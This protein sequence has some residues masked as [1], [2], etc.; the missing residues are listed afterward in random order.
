MR[1]I[2]ALLIFII[3]F[4]PFE[5][6]SQS[7]SKSVS[8]LLWQL[9]YG[10][11]TSYAFGSIHLAQQQ[12]YP[13]PK[14]VMTGFNQSDAL[15][16]EV[17]L[18][19]VT[20]QHMQALIAKYGIDSKRP[21]ASYLSKKTLKRYKDFCQNKHLPCEQFQALKPWLVSVTITA[22]L[23]AQAGFEPQYGIDKYFIAQSA[24]QKPVLP[25]ETAEQQLGLFGGLSDEVQLEM[26]KQTLSDDATEFKALIDA[27]HVGDEKALLNLFNKA[28]GTAIE[29]LFFE[30]LLYRRNVAM[31]AKLE[32]L[33]KS[34]QRLFVVIGTAHLIG[35]DNVLALL[36]A[37]GVKVTPWQ[38]KSAR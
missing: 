9:E 5:S 16:V 34:G 31:S 23:S 28:K 6:L 36:A 11:K 14:A 2:H 30:L 22:M 3:L 33:L 12:S 19:K 21:L 17:D 38:Y 10:G 18:D 13:L 37:K 25:L 29:T 32:E 7:V 15:V 4:L 35:H 8:P 20:P 26:F 27:W 24:G 1:T